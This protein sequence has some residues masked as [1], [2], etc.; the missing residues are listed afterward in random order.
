MGGGRAA[1]LPRRPGHPAPPIQ[2]IA[3]LCLT[4]ARS[5]L[6]EENDCRIEVSTACTHGQ[7][8]QGRKAHG[9][10]HRS[11]MLNGCDTRTVAQMACDEPQLL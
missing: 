7:S 11:S 1:P 10:I 6:E 3:H 4:H 9:R 5:I 2:K 8:L